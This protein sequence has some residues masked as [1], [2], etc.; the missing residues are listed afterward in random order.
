[1]VLFQWIKPL[2]SAG[3]LMAVLLLTGQLDDVQYYAQS[4]VMKTGLLAAST[5]APT[6]APADFDFGF[7][8]QDLQGNTRQASELKG[9]VVFVNLWATWCGPCRVEMPS[10][11]KLYSELAQ[12]PHV[13]FVILSIDRSEDKEKVRAYIAKKGFTFPV[14]MPFGYLP[15]QLNVPSIPTTFIIDKAGRVVQRE[16]GT[17]DFGRARFRIYLEKLAAE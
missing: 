6:E 4:A 13:A 3:M 1:M 15:E 8:L 7:A 11:Q 17:T 14:Y 16:V 5:D 12:N 9:K 10:I 2:V